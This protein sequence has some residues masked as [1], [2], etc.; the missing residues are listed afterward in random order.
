MSKLIINGTTHFKDSLCVDE[1]VKSLELDAYAHKYIVPDKVLKDVD[2]FG[3][4]IPR[5]YENVTIGIKSEGTVSITVYE[6]IMNRYD[7]SVAYIFDTGRWKHIPAVDPENPATVHDILTIASNKNE[8]KGEGRP[9][10]KTVW[11]KRNGKATCYF[12]GNISGKVTGDIYQMDTPSMYYRTM[13]DKAGYGVKIVE[14][15]DYKVRS[16]TYTNNISKVIADTWMLKAHHS[17]SEIYVNNG[18]G[19]YYLLRN[20]RADLF[21]NGLHSM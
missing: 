15:S 2:R 8:E 12:R 11:N 3:V 17:Y 7:K 19:T 14:V 18:N 9:C 10:F 16:I 4:I 13:F 21:Y 5:I 20:P 1:S 6:D